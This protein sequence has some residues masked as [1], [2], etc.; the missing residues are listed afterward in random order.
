[1]QHFALLSQPLTFPHF[2]WCGLF[3]LWNFRFMSSSIRE[4]K[5]RDRRLLTSYQLQVQEEKE[6]EE[7][8]HVCVD[9]VSCA[10]K[11]EK[12]NDIER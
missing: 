7:K 3:L 2:R 8:D 10:R 11:S 4:N 5:D 6:K 12:E 9:L 1:M